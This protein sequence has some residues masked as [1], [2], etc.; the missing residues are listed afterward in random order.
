MT[1][2]E[3]YAKREAIRCAESYLSRAVIGSDMHHVASYLKE[4]RRLHPEHNA[5][6]A[7][8]ISAHIMSLLRTYDT[9]ARLN[10]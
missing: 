8:V 4:L 6:S 1:S 5:T 10:P 7:R 2:R 9:Y 3:R